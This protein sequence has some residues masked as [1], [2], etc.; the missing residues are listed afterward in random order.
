VA[1]Q[2]VPS[3]GRSRL[4]PDPQRVLRPQP[5]DPTRC[6]AIYLWAQLAERYRN[7]SGTKLARLRSVSR[8]SYSRFASP[9]A[10]SNRPE[11]LIPKS[12]QPR[13]K[14]AFNS[15]GLRAFRT[16]TPVELQ[17]HHLNANTRTAH[18]FSSRQ[19]HADLLEIGSAS[20]GRIATD[21]SV[22]SVAI[23]E[24]PE[25]ANDIRVE[26]RLPLRP[27]IRLSNSA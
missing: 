17:S 7:W 18:R 1:A 23:S 12:R 6:C 21:P 27:T 3:R 22:I 13:R 5:A 15:I 14:L 11:K 8:S 20:V 2:A 9:I 24:M 16:N 26:R 25:Q 19:T 4:H 10:T